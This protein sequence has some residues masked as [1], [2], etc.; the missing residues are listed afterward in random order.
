MTTAPHTTYL[1][2]HAQTEYSARHLVNG[3]LAVDVPLDAHGRTACHQVA[4]PWLDTVASCRTSSFTRTHQTA[5]G[6]LAGRP[7]P[8]SADHRLNEIDYGCFE[9]GPWRDYGTWLLQAGRDAVP[10]GGA[11]SWQEA[12]LRML[13]G[14]RDCLQLPAPRLVVGHGLLG[15]VVRWLLSASPVEHLARPILPEAPYLEPVV[16]DD[17]TLMRL[18]D[19]GRDRIGPTAGRRSVLR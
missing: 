6:M 14:L 4:V 13:D 9:G 12:V 5:L 7:V 17:T 15:S 2:R 3:S 1:V 10:P 18:V 8:I 16:L 11:E 19:E